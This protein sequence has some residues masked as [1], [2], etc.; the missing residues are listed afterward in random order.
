[1]DK[2]YGWLPFLKFT[3]TFTIHF[4]RFLLNPIYSLIIYGGFL[5]LCVLF[6]WFVIKLYDYVDD[7]YELRKSRIELYEKITGKKYKGPVEYVD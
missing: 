6:Y 1:M 7:H 4:G 5:F 2:I 3:E